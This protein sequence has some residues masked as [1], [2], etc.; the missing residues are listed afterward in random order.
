[1][2]RRFGAILHDEQPYT[3]MYVRPELE[4]LHKRVKG[5]RPNLGW[6]QFETMWIDPNVAR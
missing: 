6:W 4:I 1:M 2:Y 3:F 5:A